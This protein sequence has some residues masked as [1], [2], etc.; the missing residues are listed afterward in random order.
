MKSLAVLILGSLVLAGCEKSVEHDS[1][2]APYLVGIQTIQRRAL[3]LK[4]DSH[5][6]IHEEET[7]HLYDR[8]PASNTWRT[9]GW[10]D[11][12]TPVKILKVNQYHTDTR[13]PW[14]GAIGEIQ[15]PVT[16]RQVRFLYCWSSGSL[17]KRAPWDPA[18]IPDERRC[19]ALK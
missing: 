12:G 16:K 11:P 18:S 19:P 8:D 6:E 14:I 1:Q 10:V 13:G 7:H 3:L 2:F 5:S 17:L 4:L 9:E 15:D